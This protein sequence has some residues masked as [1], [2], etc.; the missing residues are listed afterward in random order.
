MENIDMKP[1][2]WFPGHMAKTRRVIASNLKLVD[3]VAE[4]ID[5]R[6]PMGSR[7]PEIDSLT[8]GKPRILLMNKCD[9]ADQNATSIWINYF[10]N[11]GISAIP[12]DCKSQ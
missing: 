3:A 4:V 10:R 7:N 2:Q 5:A 8:A 12:V 1:I 11:R 6:V 9:L